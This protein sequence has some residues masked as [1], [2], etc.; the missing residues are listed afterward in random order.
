M[1]QHARQRCIG[2][3]LGEHGVLGGKQAARMQCLGTGLH[4]VPLQR[5]PRH[6]FPEHEHDGGLALVLAGGRLAGDQHVGVIGAHQAMLHRLGRHTAAHHAG[7]ARD[8][9]G[10]V[11]GV[12]QRRHLGAHKLRGILRRHQAGGSRVG[13]HD[14]PVHRQQH[15]IGRQ[16]RQ[17]IEVG[18][19]PASRACRNGGRLPMRRGP[20]AGCGINSRGPGIG[21]Q[22]TGHGNCDGSGNDSN[23]ITKDTASTRPAPRPYPQRRAGQKLKSVA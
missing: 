20:G 14:T 12:D 19:G 17:R 10:N 11:V 22:E 4:G 13:A 6:G 1:A 9:L 18:T 21:R 16:P 15:G 7:Q 3:E 2:G 8:R 23:G 5:M